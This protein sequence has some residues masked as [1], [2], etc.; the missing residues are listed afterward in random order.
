MTAKKQCFSVIAEQYEFI[1]EHVC[2]HNSGKAFIIY[3]CSLAKALGGGHKVSLFL[4]R[5]WQL[6][7]SC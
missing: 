4:M 6:T 3:V 2:V 7:V 1:A 5:Y